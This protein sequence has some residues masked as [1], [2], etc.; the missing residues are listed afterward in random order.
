MS[1][2]FVRDVDAGDM[3]PRQYKRP[4]DMPEKDAVR[5]M[6]LDA[7]AN[8]NG[9]AMIHNHGRRTVYRG[10]TYYFLSKVWR[11]VYVRYTNE[12]VMPHVSNNDAFD[13]EFAQLGVQQ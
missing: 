12:G 5:C 1:T 2:V 6:I 11:H 10:D 3:Y 4:Q 8:H 7:A 9:S 13:F